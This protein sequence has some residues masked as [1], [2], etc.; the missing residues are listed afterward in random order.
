MLQKCCKSLLGFGAKHWGARVFVGNGE[1]GFHFPSIPDR[2]SHPLSSAERRGY[3]RC[4]QVGRPSRSTYQE[5][6][7][8]WGGMAPRRGWVKSSK[9]PLENLE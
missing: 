4:V 3:V 9:W 2:S 7:A 5:V 6:G 1:N 8:P